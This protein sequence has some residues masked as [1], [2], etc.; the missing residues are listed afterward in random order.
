MC[1]CCFAVVG[2]LWLLCGGM[3]CV[4]RDILLMA[5]WTD[6]FT[7]SYGAKLL[8]HGDAIY[9]SARRIVTCL[10][11]PLTR[12]EQEFNTKAN[13]GRISVEWGFGRITNQFKILHQAYKLRL[14]EESLAA[15]Y[16]NCAFLTN[17]SNFAY[18]GNAETYFKCETLSLVEY[19]NGWHPATASV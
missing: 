1:A 17:M 6:I 5:R 9:S 14:R 12:E 10:P 2:C 11:G 3:T 4:H 19:L 15:L 7:N 16:Y 13:S 18:G 8:L